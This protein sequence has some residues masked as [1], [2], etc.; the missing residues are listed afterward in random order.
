MKATNITASRPAATFSARRCSQVPAFRRNTGTLFQRADFFEHPFRPVL[1][2]VGAE[3]DFLR[4][5]AEGLDVRGVDLE[6]VL[7]PEGIR[8]LRLALQVL[9][10]AP[11][12]R[13]VDRGL[14]GLLL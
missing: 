6:A 10:R 8:Q 7:L 12:K 9:G 2:L 3:V 5:L 1:R 11:G 14:E 4:V 13:L